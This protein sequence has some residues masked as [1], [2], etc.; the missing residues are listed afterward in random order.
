MAV[1]YVICMDCESPCYQFEVD[2]NDEVVEAF[3]SVCGN[4]DEDQ[5]LT[6]EDYDTLI[7][8]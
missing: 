8:G 3:C 7:G 4:E 2:I 5:F 6:E 1:E